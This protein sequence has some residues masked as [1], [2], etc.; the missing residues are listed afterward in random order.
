MFDGIFDALTSNTKIF[1]LQIG[2][3][4]TPPLPS[5]FFMAD[6]IASITVR[7]IDVSLFCVL[8]R[9]LGT[10]PLFTTGSVLLN[11][12]VGGVEQL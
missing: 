1:T 3:V 12:Q 2:A 6:V 9:M 8:F 10:E 11:K 4:D 5:L 7:Q